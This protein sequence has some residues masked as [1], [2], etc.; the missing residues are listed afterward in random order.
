M[1]TEDDVL[2]ILNCLEGANIAVWIDGGWGVD[3]LLGRATRPHD[4]LDL[5]VAR[6]D[7]Q[8]VELAL[9]RIGFSHAPQVLP[10]LPAR[11]VLR[12]A[13]GRQIDLHPLTFD[14][15]GNGRQ[16][17]G[18]GTWGTY[19]AAGLA[20]QGTV[21]GKPVRCLTPELQIAFHLGYEPD[22]DDRH[23]IRLLASHFGLLLP[24]PYQQTVR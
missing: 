5:V 15:E 14:S 6:E 2:E 17:L 19:P 3:A 7:L 24:A 12:D 1:I 11:F 18:D 23:D 9:Q 8:Q 20:G 4:D 22:D 21:R 10:G 16:D 13:A